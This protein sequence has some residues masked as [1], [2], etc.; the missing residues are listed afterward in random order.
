MNLINFYM[1]L[2]VRTKLYIFSGCFSFWLVVIAVLGVYNTHGVT[3]GVVEANKTINDIVHLEELSNECVSLRLNLVYGLIHTTRDKFDGTMID[4]DARIKRIDQMLAA[5]RQNRSI[6]DDEAKQAAAL[7]NAW[8]RYRDQAMKLMALEKSLFPGDRSSAVAFAVDNV[9]PLYKD[10]DSAITG[11]TKH[12]QSLN[13][14]M[15]KKDLAQAKLFE[16]L[17]G[18]LA[19]FSILLAAFFS[20]L[21]TRNITRPILSL[22]HNARL[23]AEGDLRVEIK[24]NL[25]D[26]IGQLAESFTLIVNCLKEMISTLADSSSQ[27]SASSGVMQASADSMANAAD[28]AVVQTTAVAVATEEMSATSGDISQNCNLAAESA[29][30][31]ND[32]AGHGAEVVENTI[33][34]MQRIAERVHASA[35]TVEELGR[36]SDQIGSIII[37][38]EDIADQTNLL[39]LNAA[40]EAARAGEQGRGFAVVAD[41]VRALA[42]RTTNAT[43]EIGTMIKSIQ[44]D[45]KSAV[46]AMEKGVAEVKQGTHEAG[47]SGEALRSIQEE[48]NNLNMQVQQMAVAAEE[49]TATT[50]EISGNIH[51]ITDVVKSTSDNARQCVVLS[52]QLATLSTAIQEVVGKFTFSESNT[53]FAWNSSYSVG[54]DPMDQEHRKLVEIINQL[55]GAMRQGKGNERIGSTLDALVEYTRT[56]FAH[57]ERLMKETG[58]AAYEEHK[59]EHD[60]LSAQVRAIQE[61]Y[62]SDSV[63]SLEVMSFVKEW[64]VNHIQGSDRRYGPHLRKS[65]RTSRAAF[66]AI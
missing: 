32:V 39:A 59:R 29:R 2:S 18:G 12:Y 63:L 36:Q 46:A 30:R 20:W 62:R 14:E 45:T 55:Y 43:R 28:H 7:D 23:M 38:I 57:E 5:S 58:Y 65:A 25:R 35:R 56:H 52:Q 11:F 37:T 66:P 60:N 50:C 41:E 34:V 3:A 33:A 31:A 13:S 54:F 21:L 26:E 40:I 51:Q 53:F 16:W 9:A 61:K 6:R 44:N 1:N 17:S 64:L 10:L 47:R 24:N 8:T 48:I 42:E 15:Y 27:I 22:S 19:I 4:A 49:Q